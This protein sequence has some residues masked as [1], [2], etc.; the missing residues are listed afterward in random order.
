MTRQISSHVFRG[1][2]YKITHNPGKHRS[3]GCDGPPDVSGKELALDRRLKGI[4]LLTTAIHEGLHATNWDLDESVV[5]TTA[6]DI[7]KFLWRLGFRQFD[8]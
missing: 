6:T 8:E 1:R 3:G 7:A 5:E 4:E 2:R